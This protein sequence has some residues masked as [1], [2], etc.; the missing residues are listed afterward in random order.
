MARGS[1]RKRGK[2]WT[3]Y[4]DAGPDPL[5]GKRR[6]VSKGGYPTRRAAEEGLAEAIA[7]RREGTLVRPSRRTVRE[8]LV[9]DWLPAKQVTLRASTWSSYR[10]LTEAYVVPLLGNARLQQLTPAQLLAFYRHLLTQ[11]RRQH[12]GGLSPKTVKNVHAMLHRALKDALQWG[13]VTRNVADAVQPPRVPKP[14]RRRW[15]PA[16]VRAFLDHV[17][18]DRLYAAWLLAAMTGMRRGELL[19]LRWLDLDLDAGVLSVRSTRVLVD[20]QVQESEPK[21]ERGRRAIRLDSATIKALQRHRD[22]QRMEHD[23]LGL[24]WQETNLVFCKPDGAPIHPERF[25]DWFKQHAKAAG[26]PVISLHGMRHSYATAGLAAG[27][28]TKVMSERLG[29]ASTAITE[30]L[31]QDVLPDTDER[32]AGLVARLILEAPALRPDSAADKPLTSKPSNE[33]VEEGGAADAAGQGGSASGGSRTPTGC[34][35]GT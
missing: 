23:L 21:T 3:W 10:M 14:K 16:Q 11:G 27:V 2:T 31:Y 22:Q 34:P 26:L 19:G 33:D 24:P 35:T 7:K 15:T 29:H 6:Q 32:V 28:P 8:F 4:L 18:G 25:S 5:T 1:I 20:N 13:Y 30:E 9:D 17:A 12:E